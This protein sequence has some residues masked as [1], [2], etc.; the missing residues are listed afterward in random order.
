VKNFLFLNFNG[1]DTVYFTGNS[2]RFATKKVKSY[3]Q[4]EL[5]DWA[6]HGVEGHFEAKKPWFSYHEFLS[7]KAAKIV[8]ALPS[9]VVDHA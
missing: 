4:A 6:Q 9:E 1:R 8:G 5:N 2:L 7:E 3:I